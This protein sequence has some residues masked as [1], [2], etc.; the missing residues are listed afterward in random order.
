LWRRVREFF[1]FIIIFIFLNFNVLV[2]SDELISNNFE[3]DIC[4]L[5]LLL[6]G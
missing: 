1:F 6:G 5:N 2:A 3:L 4:D